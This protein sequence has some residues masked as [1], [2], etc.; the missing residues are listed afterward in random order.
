[1]TNESRSR[2][3]LAWSLGRP[4]SGA[5]VLTDGRDVFSYR[6]RVGTTTGDGE[7]VAYDCHY[8]VTTARHCSAMKAVANRIEPCATCART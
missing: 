7:K 1:M 6:H 4:E 8:S 2:V 3:A 5:N